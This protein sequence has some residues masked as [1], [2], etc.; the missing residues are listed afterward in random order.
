[1]AIICNSDEFLGMLIEL[2]ILDLICT[3]S[4]ISI[5]S[6]D[7]DM[8]AEVWHIYIYDFYIILILNFHQSIMKYMQAKISNE[9]QDLKGMK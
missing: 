1:M 6:T 9:T 4:G 5:S 3:N 2:D 8:G 7:I